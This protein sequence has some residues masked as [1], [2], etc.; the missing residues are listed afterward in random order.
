MAELLRKANNLSKPAG[1]PESAWNSMP[2]NIKAQ[3]IQS[4]ANNQSRGGIST[5]SSN[6]VTTAT[7]TTPRTTT[8]TVSAPK[9]AT[10]TNNNSMQDMAKKILNVG[11]GAVATANMNN[12]NGIKVTSITANSNGTYDA[13]VKNNSGQ[14][15]DVTLIPGDSASKLSFMDNTK[16]TIRMDQNHN[17][18]TTFTGNSSISSSKTPSQPTDSVKVVS[19]VRNADG[20]Y[21]VK[22]KNS[23]GQTSDVT[24]F[25]GDDAEKTHFNNGTNVNIKMDQNNNI[26]TTMTKSGTVPSVN[27]NSNVNQTTTGVSNTTGIAAN[28]VRRSLSK[29]TLSAVTTTSGEQ[30]LF[31]SSIKEG[32]EFNINGKTYRVIQDS[33]GNQNIMKLAKYNSS[34]PDVANYAQKS[35]Y[36]SISNDYNG[37]EVYELMKD[38]NGNVIGAVHN[39]SVVKIENPSK[40][41]TNGYQIT[42]GVGYHDKSNLYFYR[43]ETGVHGFVPGG[44]AIIVETGKN[45]I[46]NSY[47]APAVKPGGEGLWKTGGLS[48]PS[49]SLNQAIDKSINNANNMRYTGVA[50]RTSSSFN[51]SGYS[52]NSAITGIT[53]NNNKSYSGQPHNVQIFTEQ[54]P[55]SANYGRV[56]KIIQDG[57]VSTN[58]G[59]TYPAQYFTRTISSDGTQINFDTG[60]NGVMYATSPNTNVKITVNGKSINN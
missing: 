56:T 27:T 41:A 16:G 31:S 28:G 44:N 34:A 53:G 42:D 45:G 26:K 58:N 30:Y 52:S 2:D 55:N 8:S 10:T 39:G 20:G 33:K 47:Q 17:I 38:S 35:I 3:A 7:T 37:K 4:A 14:I 50:N 48:Q 32:T 36:N 46:I 57:V 15:N 24:L 12:T 29:G 51:V 23:V 11:Q 9:T 59:T 1:I 54:N 21:D 18:K 49:F 40:I 60:A 22:L 19:S 5:N 13:I 43:D 25:P 6:T